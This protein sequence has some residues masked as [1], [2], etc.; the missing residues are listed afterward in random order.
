MSEAVIAMINVF[1][2]PEPPPPPEACLAPGAQAA[3]RPARDRPPAPI[4]NVRLEVRSARDARSTCR[5]FGIWYLSFK[6]AWNM[7]ISP[8]GCPGASTR[9]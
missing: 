5:S 4:R 6:N 1:E 3:S 2:P 7:F 8:T 9:A